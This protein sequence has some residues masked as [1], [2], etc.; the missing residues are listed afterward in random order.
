MKNKRRLKV[1]AASASEED[2]M[3]AAK[4]SVLKEVTD[5]TFDDAVLAN[6]KLTLVDFWAES[7]APCLALTPTLEAVLAGKT[8]TVEGF[9]IDVDQNQE[10]AARYGVRGMPTVILFR[11]GREVTRIVGSKSRAA[12]EA[13]IS[14]HQS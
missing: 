8:A 6:G 4:D 5:Q 13:A 10:T 3:K 2:G 9:M 12:Y 14:A 11:N 1:A 7:C